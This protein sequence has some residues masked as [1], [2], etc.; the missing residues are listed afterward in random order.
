MCELCYF[1]LIFAKIANVKFIEGRYY[2]KKIILVLLMA[3]FLLAGCQPTYYTDVI[4]DI[5][6]DYSGV[7]TIYGSVSSSAPELGLDEVE[8]TIVGLI[9]ELDRYQG[10]IKSEIVDSELKFEYEETFKYFSELKAIVLRVFEK[11]I[12]P[13]ETITDDIFKTELEISGLQFDHG[14]FLDDVYD[15]IEERE[16]FGVDSSKV[17]S[18]HNGTNHVQLTFDGD[19]YSSYEGIKITEDKKF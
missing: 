2:I 14:S 8:T 15:T 10:S 11:E 9:E 5:N 13:K 4:L 16:V 3:L 18:H 1:M 7:L 12:D 17:K 6:E 19:V